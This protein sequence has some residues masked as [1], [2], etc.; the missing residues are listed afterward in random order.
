MGILAFLGF[1]GTG[2]GYLQ[3]RAGSGVVICEKIVV[4]GVRSGR[5]ARASCGWVIP[6][7]EKVSETAWQMQRSR[8]S[9]GF[10]RHLLVSDLNDFGVCVEFLTGGH[11]LR[12]VSCGRLEYR[13]RRGVGITRDKRAK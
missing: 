2:R 4:E 12:F 3:K 7:T 13:S 6:Q 11:D 9:V 8:L 10:K 1:Q 5:R